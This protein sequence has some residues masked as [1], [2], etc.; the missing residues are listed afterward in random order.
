V[1]PCAIRGTRR[2]LGEGQ[3][4]LAY[5]PVSIQISPAIQPQAGD[6]RAAVNLLRDR[7]REA[8]LTNCGEPDGRAAHE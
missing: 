7:A 2:L 4:L 1:V 6:D 8:V 3:K 5:S